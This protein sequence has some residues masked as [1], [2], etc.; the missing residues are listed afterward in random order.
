MGPI[1]YG[2]AFGSQDPT[3]A[4]MQGLQGAMGMRAMLTQQQAQE[5][6]VAA[7]QAKAQQQAQ[8]QADIQSV[9]GGGTAD[10][11]A[12]LGLMGRYPQLSEQYKRVYDGLSQEQQRASVGLVAR[13][14]SALRSGQPE[15]ALKVLDEQ[16]EAA[17]NSGDTQSVSALQAIRKATEIDPSFGLTTAYSLAAASGEQG[18]KLAEAWIKEDETRRAQELQEP[19]VARAGA[20]A[21][22]AG[23]DAQTAAVTAEFARPMAET[24]IRQR[25]AQMGLTKAQTAQA[26][27]AT[28]K[29]DADRQ[30]AVLDAVA[31]NGGPGQVTLTREFGKAPQ[32]YRW[33]DSGGLEP[34]PGGPADIKASAEGKK[35]EARMRQTAQS[36]GSVLR[37][38]REAIDITGYAT[39]GA[40]GLARSIPMTDA[41]KLSGL[42]DTIKAN[43]GFDRLQ[44]MREV[45]PTGGALGAV[46]V[47]E[48]NSL[49]STVASLD[50]LQKPSDL[51]AALR[52]VDQHYSRWLETLGGSEPSTGGA[53]G[54]WDAPSAGDVVD[55][56]RFKGGNPADQ[57]SWEPVK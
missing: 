34:I 46:A 21:A 49:Q 35:N 43:I 13:V 30:Q 39:A 32:G 37:T 11:K 56:Y 31:S 6:A 52:K 14:G 15:V 18:Q 2:A 25:A 17:K 24:E 22:K 1:N 55:G 10:A 47:Q 40:G 5:Q 20:E 16:I 50:Q 26:V 57:A 42:I 53:T 23:S 8:M 9:F 48:L 3:Q 19:A 36:A 28:R 29:L 4:F 45:S 41:R 54:T 51:R 33:K 12:V 27:A 38:V 44:Q 7:A